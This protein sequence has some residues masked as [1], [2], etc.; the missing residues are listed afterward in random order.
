MRVS[1]IEDHMIKLPAALTFVALIAANVPAY[2]MDSMHG[3]MKAPT[4]AAGDPAV[5]VDTKNKTYVMA[6]EH[7]KMS[8]TH[9]GTMMHDNTMHGDNTMHKTDSMA[10][11]HMSMMCKSKADAM[12]AEMKKEAMKGNM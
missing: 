3:S 10:S 9:G 2:A 4:C 7:G 6:E 8:Q 1:H 12:G 5:M 11:G